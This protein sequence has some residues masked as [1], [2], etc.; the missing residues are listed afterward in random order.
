MNTPPLDDQLATSWAVFLSGVRLYSHN[1]RVF[2]TREGRLG[3]GPVMMQPGRGRDY[4]PFRRE[5]SICRAQTTESPCLIGQCY[6]V[7]DKVKYGK[8]TEEVLIYHHG[9]PRVTYQLC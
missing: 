3:L 4:H 2:V 8:V 9:A 5:I 7:N 6:L 1:C